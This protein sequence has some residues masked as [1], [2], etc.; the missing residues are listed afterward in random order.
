MRFLLK[1]KSWQLFA[2]IVIPAFVPN[3]YTVLMYLSLLIGLSWIYAIGVTM[4]SL[5]PVIKPDIKYFRFSLLLIIIALII[6]RIAQVGGDN[7]A[8]WFSATG[9]IIYVI[10]F[11]CAC[12]FAGKMLESV[13]E[14]EIV[15]NS[16]ALKAIICLIFFPIGL[17]HI[18]PAVQRVLAK[19]DK[20][21]V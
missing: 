17:W 8:I 2:L 14:G 16:D 3:S 18:Q 20:Q 12:G 19:Y 10:G 4:H 7:L 15:G 6:S 13:I 21:I 11:I 9:G 5:I 1:L